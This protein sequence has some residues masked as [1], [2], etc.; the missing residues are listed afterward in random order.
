MSTLTLL[1]SL[2]LASLIFINPH[3][4][5]SYL[6]VRLYRCFGMCQIMRQWKQPS[7]G[8]LAVH[9]LSS[10]APCDQDFAMVFP[11]SLIAALVL[12]STTAWLQVHQ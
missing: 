10:I 4:F 5:G 11:E 1:I 8:L 2:P 6:Y 3:P 9:L 12:C 7:F